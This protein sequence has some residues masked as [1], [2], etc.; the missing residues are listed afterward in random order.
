[1]TRTIQTI[2]LAA[3]AGLLLGILLVLVGIGRNGIRID[4]SGDVNVTG[5]HDTITLSMSEPVS[6]L[7][8]EPG[9]LIATGP[10]GEAVPA[11]ITL[12]P[13]PQCGSPMLPIR[14]SPWSGEI[15]WACSVCNERVTR[16]AEPE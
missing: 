7:M 8:E 15:E 3:C 14:W 2:A 5:M 6:L 9:H 12:L 1:M 10:N 11:A 4:L 16:P 13:C